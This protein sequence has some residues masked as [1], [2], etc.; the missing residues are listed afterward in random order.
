ML[1]VAG[2]RHDIPGAGGAGM[3]VWWHNRVG[4]PIDP[5]NPPLAEHPSL[6]TLP[7]FLEGGDHQRPAQP[8]AD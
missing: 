1:F 5:A 8:D 4:M 2:S 3:D 7:D 6:D